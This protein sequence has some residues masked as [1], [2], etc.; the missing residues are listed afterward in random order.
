MGR[1][2]KL[3]KFLTPRQ[4]ELMEYALEKGEIRIEEIELLF[5][6]EKDRRDDRLNDLIRLKL[7]KMLDYGVYVPIGLMEQEKLGGLKN[8]E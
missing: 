4:R 3:K 5:Y 2:E 1:Y 6:R 7:L 8:Y